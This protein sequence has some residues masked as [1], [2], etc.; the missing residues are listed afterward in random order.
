MATKPKTKPKTTEK[1][2]DRR[3]RARVI[4]QNLN[5]VKRLNPTRRL[6]DLR[7]GLTTS[8]ATGG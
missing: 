8:R 3:P 7:P 5:K 4:G 6:Q 1:L 2:K